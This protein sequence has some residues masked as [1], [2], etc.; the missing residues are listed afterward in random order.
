M[1]AAQVSRRSRHVVPALGPVGWSLANLGR[2]PELAF[3]SSLHL[4]GVSQLLSHH[5]DKGDSWGHEPGHAGS[6]G[7]ASFCQGYGATVHHLRGYGGK[8]AARWKEAERGRTAGLGIVDGFVEC[9]E[10]SRMKVRL[11]GGRTGLLELRASRLR[12]GTSRALLLV[13][14]LQS[15]E[16]GVSRDLEWTLWWS[17][18]WLRTEQCDFWGLWSHFEREMASHR[19]T[20]TVLFG[21]FLR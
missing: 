3:P 10:G 12:R 16:P 2:W 19:R 21:Y 5:C 14:F 17:P 13:V 6:L 20:R 4:V 7:V 18:R 15:L 8:F 9:W 1:A 11:C